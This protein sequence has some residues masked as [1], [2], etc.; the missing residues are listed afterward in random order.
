MKRTTG[1]RSQNHHIWG[2]IR[3][4]AKQQPGGKK[5][6]ESQIHWMLKCDAVDQGYPTV[7][8]IDGTVIPKSESKITTKEAYILIESIHAFADRH[9]LWLHEYNEKG[10]K[11]KMIGGIEIGKDF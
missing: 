6:S 5:F 7:E 10:K 1:W 8:W 2:H 4:I 9:L 3:D 11:I